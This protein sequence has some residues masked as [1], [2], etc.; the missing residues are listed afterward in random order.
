MTGENEKDFVDA[1]DEHWDD[2]RARFKAGRREISEESIHD[3][4]VASRRFLALLDIVRGLDPHPRVKK[5]RRSL[6]KQLDQLDQ[7]HDAQVM[8]VEI[9]QRLEQIPQLS[10]FQA[11]LEKRAMR[12]TRAARKN[13]LASKTSDLKERVKKIRAV[14]E[15]HSQETGFSKRILQA[16]DGA[17]SRTIQGF[18]EMD[19]QQPATIHHVRIAF[20]KFRYMIETVR[21]LL[22]G[23]PESYFERMHNYQDAMGKIRDTTVFL[24]TLEEFE[25]SRQKSATEVAPA[26][27]PKPISLYYKKRLAELIRAYLENK[28][29]LNTFWRAAPDQSFPWE[30]SDDSVHNPPRNRSTSGQRQQRTRRQPAAADRRRAQKD[31]P[32]RAGTEGTGNADRSDSDQS[33][34]PSG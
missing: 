29:E 9:G 1:L 30:K 26:F 31:A 25:K 21:P 34:P 12:L 33:I 2:Y 15:K 24:G 3:L 10:P 4:R 13:M 7:L 8:L 11:Y 20:K 6:K 16:V 5:M 17:Y 23:H 18:D 19:A 22:R 32:D 27:E 14:V 28:D